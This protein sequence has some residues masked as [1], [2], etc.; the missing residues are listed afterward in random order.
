MLQPVHSC[1]SVYIIH[2]LSFDSSEDSNLD[3]QIA[4]FND[5]FDAPSNGELISITLSNFS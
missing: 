3:P 5:E 1:M 2:V 4:L